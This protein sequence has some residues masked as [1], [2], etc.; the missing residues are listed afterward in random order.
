M[1]E[2]AG[3]VSPKYAEYYNKTHSA[4]AGQVPDAKPADP[5]PTNK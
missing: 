2:M 3:W 1:T 5:T 4:P